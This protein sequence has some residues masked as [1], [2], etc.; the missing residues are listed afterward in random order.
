MN[1]ELLNEEEQKITERL[2]DESGAEKAT[3]DSEG[4]ED[5]AATD[6][7]PAKKPRSPKKAAE[8]KVPKASTPPAASDAAEPSTAATKS[9][10]AVGVILTRAKSFAGRGVSGVKKG[11]PITV[12]KAKAEELIATGLF[13]KA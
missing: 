9:V 5:T 8:A 3:A 10:N 11:V 13:E 6:T 4:A 12:D 2:E 7:K 1:D